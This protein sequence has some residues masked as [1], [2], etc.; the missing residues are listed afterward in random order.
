MKKYGFIK[1]CLFC[2]E[3]FETRPRFVDY[4]SQKCKNPLNRGEYDPW[5]KGIKLTDEQKAKQ[6]TEGLK[7]GWGW[8]K[9]STNTN[10]SIKWLGSSN[11]NWEGKMNNL[12]PKKEIN[13]DFLVYKNECK[14][15]TYRSRYAMKKEGLLPENIGKRKDQ[16]QLDHIIP[17]RQGYELGINPKIIGG[18]SNLRWILGVENRKK[19]DIFQSEDILNKVLGEHNGL[20]R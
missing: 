7:K 9:G 14:K 19:W 12:R 2:K 13:N 20:L 10:Q 18:R 11:P 5:N 4:C 6:N 17:F 1:A 3:E 15:A 8:N 16:Y